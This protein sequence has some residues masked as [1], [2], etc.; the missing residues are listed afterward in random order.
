[1][2]KFCAQCGSGL[3]ESNKFCPGCG[4]ALNQNVPPAKTEPPKIEVVNG[5]NSGKAKKS[6]LCLIT[7]LGLSFFIISCVFLA[8]YYW[9]DKPHKPDTGGSVSRRIN[10]TSKNSG[11]AF[12]REI[13]KGVTLSVPENALGNRE[14]VVKPVTKPNEIVQTADKQ[15]KELGIFAVAAWEVNAGL[16]EDE[17]LPGHYTMSV[18]LSKLGIDK[19]LYDR[20][21]FYRLTDRG[22]L[23]EYSTTIKG[24]TA[25]F[26]S[27]QNSFV[28]AA[29]CVVTIGLPAVFSGATY[30]LEYGEEVSYY[31]G[32]DGDN[33][34]IECP[35]NAEPFKLIWNGNDVDKDFYSED[36]YD[37]MGKLTKRKNE[38][39]YDVKVKQEGLLGYADYAAGRVLGFEVNAEVAKAVEEAL[40]KDAEYQKLKKQVKRFPPYIERSLLQIAVAYYYLGQTAKVKMPSYTVCFYLK[41]GLKAL[42]LQTSTL[43]RNPYI[44]INISSD[45]IRTVKKGG[46]SWDNLLL[47][48]T[49]ELFHICQEEYHFSY[50]V[51]SKKFDEMVTVLLESDACAYYKSKSVKVITTN[52]EL[53]CDG[54]YE[55][56]FHYPMDKDE[57]GDEAGEYGYALSKFAMFVRK[58]CGQSSIIKAKHLMEAREYYS[59]PNISDPLMKCFK[60]DKVKLGDYF[61]SYCKSIFSDMSSSF[62]SRNYMKMVKVKPN[63]PEKIDLDFSGPFSCR[64]ARILLTEDNDCAVIVA[65][66]ENADQ[67]VL[68]CEPDKRGFSLTRGLFIPSPKGLIAGEIMMIFPPGSDDSLKT[69]VTAYA[70]PAPKFQGL[71]VVDGKNIRF[72]VPEASVAGKQG[73][74]DGFLINF[75]IGDEPAKIVLL[76]L[77]RAGKEFELN[78]SKVFPQI[79]PGEFKFTV[80]ICEYVIDKD[81]KR[82]CGPLSQE[83]AVSAVIPETEKAEEVSDERFYIYVP[84]KFN[85]GNTQV[86]RDE[87]V[88][89]LKGRFSERIRGYQEQIAKVK[90]GLK[91][92]DSS[93]RE[94]ARGKIANLQRMTEHDRKVLCNFNDPDWVNFCLGDPLSIHRSGSG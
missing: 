72:Q 83:I 74:V 40:D 78:L 56:L 61:V 17:H 10:V 71:E 8:I 16:A 49:H 9:P 3:S 43:F 47:T 92:R 13:Q 41:K 68:Y 89:I 91:S 11:N 25:S 58:E 76:E 60:I 55:Y 73:L 50:G 80:S 23:S 34:Y 64:M 5:S 87:M 84:T 70:I 42:G 88:K 94:R 24:Q 77:A 79:Q 22:E 19:S 29:V 4:R 86:S 6:P 45:L 54:P 32:R 66:Q 18:D 20:V 12:T 90:P 28:V 59:K 21:R 38:I 44:E 69:S 39:I 81:G 31:C 30:V 15:L 53:T 27:N 75:K 48:I 85:D 62:A 1:M 67:V 63:Q 51:N 93:D 26:H 52:P 57:E 33:W 37:K 35:T 82:C 65:P 2:A 36:F 7:C 46:E 14:L